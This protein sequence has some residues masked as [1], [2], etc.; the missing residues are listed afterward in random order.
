MDRFD[1]L[2]LFTRIVELGSFSRA[3]AALDIP[4]A[5]A[6]HAIKQ[7]EAS[8]GARL[9]D[10]TTR[11][12]RATPDGQA[13]YERC[14]HVL[15]ELDDAQSSLQRVAS[16]PRGL[17]R[18]DMHNT[19]ATKIVLPRIDDFR[20]RYPGIDLVVSGGDRL[21]DLVREGIDCVIRAGNPR[22]S[23]LVARRLAV[24]PQVI[25]ASPEYLAA[26][27]APRHPDELPA[28]RVVKFFAASAAVDYPLE[29]RI[30][31]EI[32]A[33]ALNGWISVSDAENYVV[34]ALR[35]CGL[36]QLPRFHVEDDLRAGRL[37]EV[38]SDWPSPD[39]PVSALYPSHRHLSP[40]VRVFVDWLGTLYEEAFPAAAPPR[41]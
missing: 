18:V 35:G 11:H 6:T 36:I 3:A 12:V 23:S 41:R 39:L 14:V 40:R 16:N 9:L 13:F 34:C 31:G 20:A 8:L 4:R 19:H 15:S 33:F 38:L 22:D 2:Q 10:R 24:M 21:V 17:L 32:R 7:L 26:F 29:L 5:T 30:G 37:V 25:C 1:S 27:G 28:H